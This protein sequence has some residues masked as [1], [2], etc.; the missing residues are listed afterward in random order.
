MKKFSRKKPFY[1]IKYFLLVIT[2]WQLSTKSKKN[3]TQINIFIYLT[4]FLKKIMSFL[5]RVDNLKNIIKKSYF[6]LKIIWLIGFFTIWTIH[7][8]V[9]VCYAHV[10]CTC[11]GCCK[12]WWCLRVPNDTPEKNFFFFKG[13]FYGVKVQKFNPYLMQFVFIFFFIFLSFIW[14][15]LV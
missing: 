3:F 4:I 15:I 7:S 1:M 13:W 10:H 5:L 6:Q 8:R 2:H 14:I 9:V 12:R 11:M